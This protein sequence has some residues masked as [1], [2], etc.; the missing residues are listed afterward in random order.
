[1]VAVQK[2]VGAYAA[3]KAGQLAGGRVEWRVLRQVVKGCG[4][5]TRRVQAMKIL[6]GFAATTKV[7]LRGGWWVQRDA[8]C[9]SNQS[10]KAFGMSS[11]SASTSKWWQ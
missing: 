6:A 2:R 4:S 7:L 3:T 1:M 5:I 11:P 8:Q 10:R 9:A